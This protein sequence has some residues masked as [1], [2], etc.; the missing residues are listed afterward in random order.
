M[1]LNNDLSLLARVLKEDTITSFQK[2][3]SERTILGTSSE[4]DTL[5]GEVELIEVFYLGLLSRAEKGDEI[6]EIYLKKAQSYSIFKCNLITDFIISDANAYPLYFN[7]LFKIENCR[8]LLLAYTD[9]RL[10]F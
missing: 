7:H 5:L 1:K 9:S 6:P 2:T 3:A 8:S 4:R 10:D